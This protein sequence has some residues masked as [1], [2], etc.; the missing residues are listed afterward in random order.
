MII[1]IYT[2]LKTLTHFSE[3]IQERNVSVVSLGSYITSAARDVS[4][5]TVHAVSRPWVTN[6]A[7]DVPNPG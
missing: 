6:Y 1:L 2:T 7:D 4:L 3:I 5:R